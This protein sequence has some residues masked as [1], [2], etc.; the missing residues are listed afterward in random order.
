[1]VHRSVIILLTALAFALPFVD[2]SPTSFDSETG[3]KATG[4]Q[5]YKVYRIY[6]N[7]SQELDNCVDIWKSAAKYHLNFWK[8]PSRVGSAI[9]VMVSPKMSMQF[10]DILSE[11][12]LDYI[13]TIQDVQ[14]LIEERESRGAPDDLSRFE[15]KMRDNFDNNDGPFY[16]FQ[17][18][19]PYEHMRLYMREIE[20]R[21]PDLAKVYTIGFSVEGRPIEMIKIGFPLTKRGKKSMWIDA[22]IHAREWPSSTTAIYFMQQLITQ[23]GKDP[24]ITQYVQEL[25]W[26]IVPLLNPDGHEYS[27]S[28]TDPEIRMWRK[29]R[30][31]N[32]EACRNRVKCC[33]GVDLNRNFDFHWGETGASTEACEEIYQGNAPFSEPEARAVRDF[34]LSHKNDIQAV[35]TMHTYSQIWI[36]PYGHVRHNYPPDVNDLK[37]TGERA[38]AALEKVYGTKYTV[39]SGADTL[40]P[41][42]GGSDDWSKSKAGIKFVYLLELRPA[43]SVIDGFIL[44]PRYL[45]P[46]GRETWEGV[47]VVA[48]TVLRRLNIEPNNN[49]DNSKASQPFHSRKTNK[50]NVR[51]QTQD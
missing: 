9:D 12:K 7:S 22:G 42:S 20:K 27:R 28:S 34:I 30:S 10:E 26:Y 44:E 18:Y 17:H 46:T 15:Q 16:D 51:E 4:A 33:M 38:A 1:M 40:Y 49:G 29:N 3:D 35:I 41:A 8:E 45:Q 47:K 19:Y 43:D 37:E 39:G 6:P 5:P 50:R 24:L 11:R 32:T 21:H 25:N 14:K 2:L 23:Y 48:N 31:K 13:V 36:H